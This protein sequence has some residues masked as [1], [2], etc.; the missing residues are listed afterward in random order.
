MF[1]VNILK[2]IGGSDFVSIVNN[3]MSKLMTNCLAI[4]YSFIGK[5]KKKSFKDELPTHLRLII[6]KLKNKIVVL[7]IFRFLLIDLIF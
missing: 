4:S 5:Q 2:S 3:V 6:S 7:M 1:Q